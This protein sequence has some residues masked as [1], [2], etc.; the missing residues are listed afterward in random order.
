ME[1]LSA[2]SRKLEMMFWKIH[3]SAFR[4]LHLISDLDK[5]HGSAICI[6]HPI[7][8]LWPGN[9]PRQ[10]SMAQDECGKT[11]AENDCRKIVVWKDI[12]RS[13]VR[14]NLNLKSTA[15]ESCKSLE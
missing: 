2:E 3:K 8:D 5:F 6:P 13:M 10:I 9:N 14:K 4:Y 7:S 15:Q 1:I 11:T 12:L